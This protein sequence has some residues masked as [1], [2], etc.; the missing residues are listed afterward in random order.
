MTVEQQKNSSTDYWTS[1]VEKSKN[2]YKKQS[3]YFENQT[4][5]FYSRPSKCLVSY[6]GIAQGC[7]N[8][9]LIGVT[10]I[11]IYV[12]SHSIPK[13]EFYSHSRGI[14]ISIGNPISIV[15][16]SD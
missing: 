9:W 15:I 2:I 3:Q 8:P 5:Y 12:H 14:S 13:L 4:K 7:T 16:S 11:L 6:S 1:F 10:F